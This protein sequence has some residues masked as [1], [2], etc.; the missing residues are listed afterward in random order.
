MRKQMVAWVEK[1]NVDS[2]LVASIVATQLVRLSQMALATPEL[3]D[4]QV[5]KRLR[6]P[7]GSWKRDEHGRIMTKLVV[8]EAVRLIE[9]SSKLEAGLELFKDHDEKQF[10]V[11][12][13]SKQMAYLAQRR[14]ERAGIE[15]F[16]LSGDTPQRERDGMVK[17]FVDGD[18]QLFIGVIAAMGEGIDG[19]QY[20]TDTMVFFDRSWSAFRGFQTEDRLHRDGQKNTVQIIDIMARNTLDFGRRTK[21][22]RKWSWLKAILGDP[23]SAQED[24]L[25]NY[26]S[27]NE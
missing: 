7:D 11:A 18:A 22:L 27:G 13:S 26:R 9:P 4:R 1:Q 24:L 21:L 3:Y 5:R 23:A 15:S 10:V 2:P 19:L 8:E 14:Y 17:R 12:T 16:V 20:A 6:N 25:H